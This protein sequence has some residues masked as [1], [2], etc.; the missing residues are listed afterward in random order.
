MCHDGT[1]RRVE[2]WRACERPAPEYLVGV[3][4][5]RNWHNDLQ[6][7]LHAIREP[8]NGQHEDKKRL[9]LLVLQVQLQIETGIVVGRRSSRRAP[10]GRPRNEERHV[11]GVL[12]VLLRKTTAHPAPLALHRGR[13]DQG[14]KGDH[15]EKQRPVH[16]DREARSDQKAAKI[17]RI[18]RMRIWAGD[19]QTLVLDDV[20]RGPASNEDANEGDGGT[21]RQ[22]QGRRAREDEVQRGEQESEREPEAFGEE[23]IVQSEISFSR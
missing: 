13:I 4:P 7:P 21:D 20:S 23:R 2:Q 16:G 9:P 17:Q 22:R 1:S 11:A 5:F 18:A 3:I 12:I 15:E 10:R 14:E 19:G 8:R 6:P